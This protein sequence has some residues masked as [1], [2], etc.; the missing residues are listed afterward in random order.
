MLQFTQRF[1]AA[2]RSL[3]RGLSVALAG[4][5]ALTLLPA[6]VAHADTSNSLTVIGTSDVSDSGLIPNLIGPEF[7]QAFPQYAF[8]YLGNA[9]LT[10]INDAKAG[11][12][13]PSVLIVHA[14]S[15][16]NQ[17]VSQGFSY[18]NQYGNAIF[19]NDF[20]LAGP[21]AANDANS[22]NVSGTGSTNGTHNIVQAF[23]D[24]ANAGYNGGGTP[25]ATFISRG[26]APGTV[27]AEH[28]IWAQAVAD[29][30]VTLPPASNVLFCVVSDSN[31]GGDAPIAPGNGVTADGQPCPNSGANPPEAQVP[32]WYVVTGF[33]Q[34]PN[35]VDANTCTP[36]APILS[37]ANSCYVFTDRGTYDYLSSGTD[38]SGAANSFLTIP[39]LSILTSD[40]AASA[41]G[42][43][44]E[45]I[46]YFH[47]YIINPSAPNETV[48]LPAA[49]AFLSFITSPAVQSQLVNYLSHNTN[50]TLGPPFVADASPTITESGFPASDP[51][52]HAVTVTGKVTNTEPGF[53][54]P[55]GE[56]VSVDE[57]VGGAPQAIPGATAAVDASDN[58][59]ITFVPPANGEYEVSTAPI[60]LVE[61]STLSPVYGDILS[62]GSTSPVAVTVQS[63][64][65]I[66]SANASPGGVT[67]SGA[68]AP[69]ALDAN[70]KVTILARPSGSTGAFSEIGAGGVAQSQSGYAI[71]GS[72]GAGSWQVEASYSDDGQVAGS[73]SQPASVTIAA[74]A[75]SHTVKLGKITAKKGKVTVSGTLTPTPT[76]SGAKVTLLALRASKLGKPKSKSKKGVRAVAAAAGLKSV[77]KTSVGVGKS[78]FNVTA[79]LPRGFHWIVQLE[80]VQ[81]GQSSAFS[82]LGAVNVK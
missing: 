30:D 38:P 70:G 4:V 57:V 5:A 80:Y 71:S 10:A 36:G 31:G 29:P 77:A 63:G 46:N 60:S 51:A 18:Q 37:G 55:T 45:L 72:L 66:A 21:T 15:L 49:Q 22:A 23:A 47:A 12:F 24:I 19:Y 27:V 68:V 39:N 52:G 2:G 53:P 25:K 78:S 7:E 44:N 64:V 43:T 69:A 17:F 34:G 48:N 58:Y 11:T 61:N 41:P 14:P 73:T 62:P 54:N 33:T 50:D 82:K 8:K 67:V 40:N 28:A 81:T 56:T 35:V 59:S 75:A 13:G 16:E 65:T 76:A 9:T 26:G 79:K 3:R 42:G 1:I 6:A 20:I 74:G 32:S